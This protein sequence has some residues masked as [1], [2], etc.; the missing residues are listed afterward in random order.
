MKNATTDYP[1]LTVSSSPHIR[2]QETI[3]RIMW[4]VV[5]ALL[6]ATLFSIYLFGLPALKTIAWCIGACVGSEFL[7]QNWQNKRPSITDGSAVITGLLLAMNL[8]ANLPWYMCISGAVVAIGLAKHTMGG[9]GYNIF[10]PALIGRAFLM[11]SWPLAMTTWP[12][13]DFYQQLDSLPHVTNKVDALTAA[14]PLGILKGQGYEAL[15]QSFGSNQDLYTALFLGLRGGCL[16]ETSC[17]LLLLGGFFL[18]YRGY[19]NWQVPVTMIATVGVLSWIFGGSTLFSGDPLLHMLSGGLFLG[20]FFMAT[21]MVTIPITK[22]GQFVF[23][24]GAG[25]IATLIRLK[26]GYPEGVSY[27][28][29]LMNAVT[30]LIDKLIKPTPFGHRR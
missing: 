25:I 6:P 9:L 16:G 8:P 11:A 5:F 10:N 15:V 7:I 28:I 3:A 19:I 4:S 17:L 21:D 20:A 18:I 22:K 30:P 24:L 2:N 1:L 13:V 12:K 29:L 27:S 26:G 14:T 23:A